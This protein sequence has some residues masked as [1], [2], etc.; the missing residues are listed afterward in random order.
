MLV[1]FS[2]LYLSSNLI[3]AVDKKKPR[4]I[5]DIAW[6]G[7]K[8]IT[9][10]GTRTQI[11]LPIPMKYNITNSFN[12]IHVIVNPA[13]TMLRHNGGVAA[14]IRKAAGPQLQKW[15]HAI[16]VK[17]GT[18]VPVGQALV[19]PAF[20]LKTKGIQYIVHTVGPDV[21]T[22]KD[23][24]KNGDIYLYNAW[25]NAL[26]AAADYDKAIRNIIFPSIS[27]GIFGFSKKRAADIALRAIADFIQKNPNR[28]DYI[29]IALWPDTYEAY[30]KA[31][32]KVMDI[33]EIRNC[34]HP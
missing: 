27:T 10:E 22:D 26:Q 16:P 32:G 17:N 11:V 13:N 1:M 18:R 14:D 8:H 5:I 3:Q 33:V 6:S 2:A 20:N 4:A 30:D 19:S 9:L 25:Y 24:R 23:Q 29:I 15:S 7:R 12:G 28:F 34:N 31:I 21:R